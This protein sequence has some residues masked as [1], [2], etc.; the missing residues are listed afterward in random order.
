MFAGEDSRKA[1]Y[2]SLSIT[3]KYELLISLVHRNLK[4][5]EG[6]LSR[7]V[8][9]DFHFSG[10]VVHNDRGLYL[11]EYRSLQ[12]PS[13]QRLIPE[14]EV[15][16]FSWAIGIVNSDHLTSTMLVGRALTEPREAIPC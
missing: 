3:S 6:N 4:L 15:D 10:K 8:I 9:K 7:E 5:N 11:P 14:E 2:N 12:H 13:K 1:G 16:G